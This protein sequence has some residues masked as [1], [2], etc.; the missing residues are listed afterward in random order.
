MRFRPLLAVV[1]ALCLSLVTACSG[2]A[3]AV[4]RG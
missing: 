3:R 1:L 4:D 2:G